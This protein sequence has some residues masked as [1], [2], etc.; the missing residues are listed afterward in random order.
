MPL[1]SQANNVRYERSRLETARK[2]SIK[3]HPTFLVC[4]LGSRANLAKNLEK[5]SNFMALNS[6]FTAACANND[7]L[8]MIHIN[9]M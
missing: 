7:I 1:L 6:I 4:K 5:V 2:D 8:P 9:K 3:C